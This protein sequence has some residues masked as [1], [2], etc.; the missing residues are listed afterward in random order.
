MFQVL[1]LALAIW[2]GGRLA[3]MPVRLRGGLVGL[4][5]VAVVLAHL[6]LPPEAP[7]RQAT[8]GRVE[9][10]LVLGG[11]GLL[12][13]GYL[14]VLRALRA[15]ARPAAVAVSGDRL[16][17][18]E[19][20]RYARHIVLRELG[21]AGQRRLKAARVLVVG[22]GGL[23]S[24]VILYLAAAGVGTITLVDDDRVEPGNLQ[25]QILHSDAR[26]GLPKVRSAV[27]AAAALNPFVTLRPVQQRL[28]DDLAR[29]LIADQD[30]V[31]DGSDNFATRQMVNRHCADLGVP[32]VSGAIAQWDGQ[33]AVY[34]PARGGPCMACVFP[35]APAAGLAPDCAAAGVVGP[36]AGIIG[37]TMALEAIKR[38]TGAGE[39]LTG[40][41][42]L[43][44]A[45]QAE[46]RVIAIARRADCPVCGKVLP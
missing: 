36:L 12:L 43:H 46:T 41:L 13:L 25:R 31:L 38:L 8:G 7:V 24:P 19:L 1:A 16:T 5:Y 45:L 32:L 28:D 4:L 3:G 15:R 20:D 40:R 34:D 29:A 44:D 26:I 42:M 6:L 22:A 33:V 21:G 9:P 30:L 39:T 27:I 10:W 17:E 23:G 18:T 2:F 37:S 35:V 14:A 11:L